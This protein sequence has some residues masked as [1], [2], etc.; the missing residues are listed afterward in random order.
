MASALIKNPKI[1]LL[2]EATASLDS[3]SE[4]CVQ[5]ALKEV[6]KGRTTVTVA[7]RLSTIKEADN[8]VVLSN[9]RVVEQGPHSS[10]LEQ[11][12]AYA[13]MIAA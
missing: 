6:L 8:I 12:G 9:G 4:Q 11:N 10:L 1:L 7:H 5:I 13:A 2:D 3:A